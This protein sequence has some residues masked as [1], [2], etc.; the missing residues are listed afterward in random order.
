MAEPTPRWRLSSVSA[1]QR[2]S[3]VFCFFP[4]LVLLFSTTTPPQR[5][6]TAETALRTTRDDEGITETTRDEP[7]GLETGRTRSA[8]HNDYQI[9]VDSCRRYWT[10]TNVSQLSTTPQPRS[11]LLI[12]S[13]RIRLVILHDAF[14][15]FR[16]AFPWLNS[17]LI[18]S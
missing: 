2:R 5:H 1:S 17:I 18:G 13:L 16:L 7:R 9:I 15:F 10:H 3:A 8:S 4:R 14:P 12:A 11:R 6:R